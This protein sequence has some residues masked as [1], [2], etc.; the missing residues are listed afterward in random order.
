MFR[1]RVRDWLAENLPPKL[2]DER[3]EDAYPGEERRE[4]VLEFNR[5]H[6]RQGWLAAAWPREYGGLGAGYMDQYILSE[7]GCYAVA[8]L[9]ININRV[10]YTG[11]TIMASVTSSAA[12]PALLV[13]AHPRSSAT[14]SLRAASD[15]RGPNSAAG[16]SAQWS[17][18]AA[19]C[20]GY[21]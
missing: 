9:I 14:S 13:A 8:P 17:W 11:P 19:C 10:G 2:T 15:C 7:E 12:R 16:R 1:T 21:G 3:T 20:R 6:A 5:S 18:F 4:A